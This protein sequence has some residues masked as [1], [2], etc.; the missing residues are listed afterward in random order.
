[1]LVL[2]H[3]VLV[4]NSRYMF[5]GKYCS[6]DSAPRFF[7]ESP[8]MTRKQ[9]GN[10]VRQSAVVM[11][12]DTI[13][14]G[15]NKSWGLCTINDYHI[16]VGFTYLRLHRLCVLFTRFWFHKWNTL[17]RSFCSDNELCMSHSLDVDKQNTAVS[18]TVVLRALQCAWWKRM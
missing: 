6:E 5:T 4:L 3:R 12:G 10:S 11:E 18:L 14:S 16:V 2:S 1:M 15:D 8:K 9:A 13:M 17:C 7:L